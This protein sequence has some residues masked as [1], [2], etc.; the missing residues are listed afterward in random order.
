MVVLVLSN[1]RVQSQRGTARIN[2]VSRPFDP[3]QRHQRVIA[4]RDDCGERPQS[5]PSFQGRAKRSC[6]RGTAGGRHP[7]CLGSAGLDIRI[8]ALALSC[9]LAPR[10]AHSRAVSSGCCASLGLQMGLWARLGHREGP[11]TTKG[12]LRNMGPGNAHPASADGADGGGRT[13]E[14]APGRRMLHAQLLQ[15]CQSSID[16]LARRDAGTPRLRGQ[17]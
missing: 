11:A 10:R 12:C 5:Q 3:I 16:L 6:T 4:A 13:S 15:P 17:V 14:R 9:L 8:S 1:S 7:A 2:R